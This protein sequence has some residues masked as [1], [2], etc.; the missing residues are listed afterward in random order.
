MGKALASFSIKKYYLDPEKPTGK[1][2]VHLILR[3]NLPA[4]P[5][6]NSHDT[7]PGN[8]RWFFIFPPQTG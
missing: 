5:L 2:S 1:M 4:A 8:L 7:L 6:H 3:H